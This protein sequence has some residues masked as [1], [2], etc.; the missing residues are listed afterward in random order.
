MLEQLQQFIERLVSSS[1]EETLCVVLEFL[2]LAKAQRDLVLLPLEVG[3]RAERD[4][5]WE[6]QAPRRCLKALLVR[7]ELRV[8][9]L[10]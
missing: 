8:A 9:C 10:A 2:T 6:P 1:I 3:W 4:L 7:A 5:W